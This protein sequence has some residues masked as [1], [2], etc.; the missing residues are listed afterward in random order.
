METILN[1]TKQNFIAIGL[2]NEFDL[3]H[4]ECEVKKK[5]DGET[6]SSE[7]IRGKISVRIGNNVKVFDVFCTKD[8]AKGEES[9]QW[10]NALKWLELVPEINSTIT[11]VFGDEKKE[12]ITGD[13]DNASLVSV[14]GRVA[15]N[16]YYNPKTKEAATILRWNATRVSTSRV[17]EDDIQGCTL[18]GTFYIKS[19]SAEMNG[20]EETGRL[21]VTLV[22][23]DYG[24]TPMLIDT[25]VDE[26]LV[27][28]FSDMYEIGQT[29]SFDIDVVFEHIGAKETSGQKAFGKSGSIKATGYDKELLMIT[30]GDEPIEE[31]DE[32]D[33]DGNPID[34]GYIDP[35]T[36]KAA[37]K[38]REALL[39]E[40]KENEGGN[41]TTKRKPTGTTNLKEKKKLNATKAKKEPDY[42]DDD[43]SPF[44]DEDDDF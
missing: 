7:R 37:L 18:S 16:R 10:K 19:M 30:G 2:V 4:E 6:I 41:K 38:E 34:N 29:A 5:D 12:T 39:A 13:R 43:E 14:S 1:Q 20:E 44:D 15:E 3:T 27:E 32:E 24:A 25:I 23:V 31:S 9:K 42:P 17:S 8:T 35:K 33:E 26:D 22:G 28:A 40:I 36:M 21:K 11:Y